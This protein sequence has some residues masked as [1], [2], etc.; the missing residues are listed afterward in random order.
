MHYLT[1]NQALEIYRRIGIQFG[2][3]LG[4]LNMFSWNSLKG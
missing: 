4:I 2:G 1:L 3:A